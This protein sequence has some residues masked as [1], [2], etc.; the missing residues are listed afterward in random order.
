MKHKQEVS[1]K[2]I[3]HV[4]ELLRKNRCL[5]AEREAEMEQRYLITLKQQTQAQNYHHIYEVQIKRLKESL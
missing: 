1:Q 3:S 4:R 2:E 5:F